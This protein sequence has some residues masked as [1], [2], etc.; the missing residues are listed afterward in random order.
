MMA[1]ECWQSVTR[2]SENTETD[3]LRAF[4]SPLPQGALGSRLRALWREL[5]FVE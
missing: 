2:V 4:H 3:I 5:S 1:Q